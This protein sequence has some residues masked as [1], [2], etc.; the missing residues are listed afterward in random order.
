MSF[1]NSDAVSFDFG[2]NVEEERGDGYEVNPRSWT[3]PFLW[4]SC[5]K[6]I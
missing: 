5:N 3:Q 6:T 1:G 2:I 4:V